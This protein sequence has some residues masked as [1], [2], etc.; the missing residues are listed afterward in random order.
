MNLNKE[1]ISKKIWDVV[2]IGGGPAGMMTAG[3]S[4]ERGLSVLVLEKNPN[5]GRK[6]LLTG[7]GRC[8]ITN[9]KTNIRD[10]AE[11]YKEGGK[12]LFST[13]SQHAVTDSIAFFESLH[14][15]LHEENE[16]RMFPTTNSSETVRDALVAHMK[17]TNVRVQKNST[18]TGITKNAKDGVF[19]ISVQDDNPLYARTCVVATGGTSHPKTGS[20]GECFEWLKTLGHTIKKNNSA[21]VPVALKET[22]CKECAGLT[23]PESKLIL[24]S[25]NE[26]VS[27]HTGK[28]LFTHIGLSGPMVLNMSATI[29]TLLTKGSVTLALD[30]FPS[31][32]PENL[33][34]IVQNLLVQESNKKIKNTLPQLIPTGLVEPILRLIKIDS[35][36]PCHS[37]KTKE[38]KKLLAILK[39]VPLTVK[40]LLGADKAI[41][42]SGGI[43]PTEVNF[44]TM[45]S[46]IVQGLYIVGD[47]LDI[48]RPSGGYSLQLCWSTGYVAG[49]HVLSI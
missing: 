45:E 10:L 6:L 16:G 12:F 39:S 2:I 3:R 40:A 19:C 34:T 15:S 17:N 33:R 7:G 24:Y 5:L 20:T 35:E 8:N 31:V 23:L 18:I 36:T 9:N 48:E 30:L 46:R 38:R 25:N 27:I 29:G 4:G 1:K 37:V 42:S 11:K 43:S 44:K 47:V 21:L 26:K 41:V 32:T 49:S 28:L 22:W 13:F 14:V